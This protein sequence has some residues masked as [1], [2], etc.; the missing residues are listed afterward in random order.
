MATGTPVAL[1]SASKLASLIADAIAGGATTL[2]DVVTELQT[3]VTALGDLADLKT[4]T[5]GLESALTTT[6]DRLADLKTYTDGIE[7]LLGDLKTYT[8][9]LE[10]LLAENRGRTLKVAAI[11]L[12]ADGEI[13]AA[14]T[15]KVIKVVYIHFM[16]AAAAAF[17]WKTDGSGG[18]AL[19]GSI[20]Y[21]VSGGLST[22]FVPPPGYLMKTAVGKNLY[23]DFQT[24]GQVSGWL[25]YFDDDAS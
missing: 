11:S 6:N 25:V 12:A 8:D 16:C 20:S 5:D 10:G 19:S 13:L 18:T 9:G 14:V 24:A 2:A 15:G 7:T 22:P 4:Y 3:V 17:T 21:P 1:T 23:M